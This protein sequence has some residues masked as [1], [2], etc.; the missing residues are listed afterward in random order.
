MSW[1]LGLSVGPGGVGS[2]VASDE[3]GVRLTGTFP[4]IGDAVRAALRE[5]DGPP[6]RVTLVHPSGVTM[7]ELRSE[8]GDLALAGVPDDNAQLRADVEVLSALTG[9]HV[10]LIDADRDL[11]AAHP[12]R[13]EPFDPAR[14]AALV[15]REPGEVTVA[16]TGHPETRD[17][18]HVEARDY[19]P[20]LV[21]RPALAGL[22]LQI[23]ATSVL[24]TTPRT[25][26]ALRTRTPIPPVLIAIPVLA[27]IL[28]LLLL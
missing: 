22:A 2:A 16:L 7:R 9:N 20:M 17:R 5:N 26:G 19:A 25:A 13:T 23:P 1:S 18:Y 14:L 15:A 28:L 24:V 12:G 21:E 3:G 10:L 4:T 11:L 8:I 27:I 6:A